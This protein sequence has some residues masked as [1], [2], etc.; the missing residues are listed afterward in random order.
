LDALYL[1]TA[2]AC[3]C[4]HVAGLAPCLRCIY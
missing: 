4:R 2:F 1:S 3:H